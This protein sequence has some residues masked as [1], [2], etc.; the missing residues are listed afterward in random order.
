M[1]VATTNLLETRCHPTGE[2]EEV[3]STHLPP[4]RTV[5]LAVALS[6]AGVLALLVALHWQLI[7]G[8][9]ITLGALRLRYG[10]RGRRSLLE[11]LGLG[12]GGLVGWRG[13]RAES[14]RRAEQHA[15]K[16]ETEQA[17]AEELRSRAARHRRTASE[18]EAAEHKAYHRGIIDGQDA[19][20][21]GFRA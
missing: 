11:A 18:Q 10:R 16:L 2:S 8:W 12:V 21:A 5:L 1:L 6:A 17:R 13:L 9:G 3:M 7:L 19:L 20:Q 4:R 15:A 14:Q